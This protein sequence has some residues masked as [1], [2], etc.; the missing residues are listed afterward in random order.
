MP[1]L[2]LRRIA[3][4]RLGVLRTNRGESVR[5]DFARNTGCGFGR[6]C[7]PLLQCGIGSL[8]LDGV[9]YYGIADEAVSGGKLFALGITR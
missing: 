3:V 7:H 4:G 1:D 6:R 2:G 9:F 8:A 5:R